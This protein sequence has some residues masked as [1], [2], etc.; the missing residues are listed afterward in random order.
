M[1]IK[2]LIKEKKEKE[3]YLFTS[4]NGT[5]VTSDIPPEKRTLK[6]IPKYANK[7]SKIKFQ[8]WLGLK[9][10][11]SKGYDGKW[12]GWSH[13][14]VYGFG[15]GDKIKEGDVPYR[16]KEYTIK[17]DKQAKETATIFRDEVS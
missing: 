5:K 13:R 2:R 6:N 15:I 3:L 16:G 7:K 8:D 9:G 12:Y 11:P 10:N 14:A 4:F 17:D 1:I